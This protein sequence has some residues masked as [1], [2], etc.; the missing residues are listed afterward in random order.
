[1]S[2]ASGKLPSFAGELEEAVAAARSRSTSG[3]LMGGEVPKR[4]PAEV[5]DG[6]ASSSVSES[7]REVAGF[8][9]VL[10]VVV[11]GTSCVPALSSASACTGLV[12]LR[13]GW[14]LLKLI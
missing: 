13:F 1:M 14:G 5:V 9:S 11:A 3:P 12:R 2:E 8:S 7:A 4:M 6:S 10:L